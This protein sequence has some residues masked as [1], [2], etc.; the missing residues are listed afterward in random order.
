LRQV[1]VFLLQSRI[2]THFKLAH[3]LNGKKYPHRQEGD[4]SANELNGPT[5][6]IRVLH[7]GASRP[8]I[9]ELLHFCAAALNQDSQ[10]DD[11]QHASYN[12]ND[13]GTIHNNSSFHATT[14]LMRSLF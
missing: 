13:Q 10:N 14:C 5:G 6:A 2:T 3:C 7:G 4:P 11:D 1:T 9:L 12:P 8:V